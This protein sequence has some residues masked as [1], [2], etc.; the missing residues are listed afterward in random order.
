MRRNICPLK[1]P[2]RGSLFIAF[3]FLMMSYS[4]CYGQDVEA[5]KKDPR[6]IWGES[7]EMSTSEMARMDAV[8]E[9]FKKLALLIESTYSES[10]LAMDSPRFSMKSYYNVI[11][12]DFMSSIELSA[13]PNAKSFVYIERNKVRNVFNERQQRTQKYIEQ[14]L[15]SESRLNI[16]DALRNYYWALVLAKSLPKD[17]SVDISIGE[18]EGEARVLIPMKLRSIFRQLDCKVVDTGTN[19]FG[20]MTLNLQFT[21]NGNP[22]SSLRYYYH[23][24]EH[25]QGPIIV[26]DGFGEASLREIHI[27]NKLYIRYE[28]RFEKESEGILP[29]VLKNIPP[30]SI[31][32]SSCGYPI[33]NAS[34]S[35]KTRKE[36]KLAAANAAADI[37]PE[38]AE[39]FPKT[40]QDT[41]DPAPYMKAMA[42]IEKAIAENKPSLA[43]EYMTPECY[44]LFRRLLT[45]TGKVSLVSRKQHYQCV[46]DSAD[47]TIRCQWMRCKL[48]VGGGKSP[49]KTYQEKLVFRFSPIDN[50]V[51][52]FAFGLSNQ[53]ESDIFSAYKSWP[54]V[55]RYTILKFMEDYQTAFA[56]KRIDYLESIFSDDAVIII[57]NVLP[58]KPKTATDAVQIEPLYNTNVVYSKKTKSQYISS[59]KK[60]MQRWEYVHLTLE[61]NTTKELNTGG[62]YPKGSFFGIQI[63]Q[64][65]ESSTYSDHG[66]LTLLL[67]MTGAHPVIEVR[68]WQPEKQDGM[69]ATNFKKEK[70]GEIFNADNIKFY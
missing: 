56:L 32:E 34:T 55:S 69:A 4:L 13:P 41:I 3:I 58:V 7:E 70:I 33:G 25:E 47:R 52:S 38:E 23:D 8:E 12:D 18:S 29:G 6:Y 2:N 36:R 57:G 48:K 45:Q 10:G 64:L 14:A 17:Y 50:T 43:H 15:L 51:Q 1:T 35:R 67:N 60:K 63:G 65:H 19:I 61:D 30:E 53:A 46:V 37:K 59:L 11:M 21:Y 66:Y 39:L 9:M 5:I 28:Y 24:G 20:D 16:D 27:D 22:V 26:K 31:M 44:E 49:Q 40:G 68:Y 54:N 62:R 42:S